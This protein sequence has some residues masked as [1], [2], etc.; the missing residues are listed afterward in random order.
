MKVKSCFASQTAA[1]VG[2]QRH[3]LA[4]FFFVGWNLVW[5][6]IIIVDM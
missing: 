5:A 4:S 2:L 3:T 1:L 6:S